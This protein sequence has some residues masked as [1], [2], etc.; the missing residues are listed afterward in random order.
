MATTTP[1]R[2]PRP[3]RACLHQIRQQGLALTGFLA[4]YSGLTRQ[5]HQLDLRQFASWCQQPQ[6][7]LFQARRADIE[8]YAPQLK[9][10]FQGGRDTPRRSASYNTLLGTAELQAARQSFPAGIP[11]I[12][13]FIVL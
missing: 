4:A 2:C 7:R 11:G 5:A 3:V 1:V 9:R 6:L 13:S 12:T 8:F 10:E